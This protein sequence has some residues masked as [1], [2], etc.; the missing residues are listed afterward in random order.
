[1]RRYVNLCVAGAAV[2]A[3][4]GAAGP[5]LAAAASPPLATAA[6]PPVRHVVIIYLENHSFDNVLG[7]WCDVHL[8]RCPD[9]GM[10]AKVK[11]SNGA[12]V[13]STVD[14]D[15]IPD[16]DHSGPSQVTAMDHGKMDGWD[17]IKPRAKMI[18][19]GAEYSYI[20]V[21]GYK[22]REEPN[23]ATLAKKFAI[24][25]MTFSM[26]DSPSWEGHIYAV[27]ASTDGFWGQTPQPPPGAARKLGW[28]CDSNKIVNWFSPSGTELKEPS[29][30]PDPSLS[31]PNGGAFEPTSVQYIPTIMDRLDNAGLTW[32][33]YGAVKGQGSYGLW[34]ICPTFAECLYTPQDKNLVANSQFARTPRAATFPASLL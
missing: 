16:V 32:K 20:C 3:L 11:L 15:T 10:P 1:M 2:A 9:G 26:S 33:I 13:K 8:A 21:S 5:P 22:P 27:A 6:A 14:P 12:V 31:L 25:D 7:F 34:D 4:A 30:V 28:G 17:R 23:F 18:G 29:C 24:S 19:C